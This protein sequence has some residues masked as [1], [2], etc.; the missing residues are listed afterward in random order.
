MWYSWQNSF[1]MGYE[2]FLV[3]MLV[4]EIGK[5]LVR[6]RVDRAIKRTFRIGKVIHGPNL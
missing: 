4:I 1:A 6:G 2:M 5:W 3:Y